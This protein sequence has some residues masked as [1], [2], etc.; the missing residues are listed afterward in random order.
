MT[1]ETHFKHNQF[2]AYRSTNS[3]SEINHLSS[4]AIKK[5]QLTKTKFYQG[6]S[7]PSSHTKP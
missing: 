6:L 1:L 2:I 7:F 5:V 3:V 4:Y